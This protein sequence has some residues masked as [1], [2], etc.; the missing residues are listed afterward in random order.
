MT[1]LAT[2]SADPYWRQRK[3]ASAGEALSLL[4]G[5]AQRRQ[6][7]RR[8]RA[9][10]DIARFWKIGE[11]MPGVAAGAYGQSLVQ[12]YGKEFP[13]VR[14]LVETF[15]QRDKIGRTVDRAKTRYLDTLAEL[16]TDYQ[17]Q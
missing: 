17:T 12:K 8:Q 15:E 10:D 13:E 14:S 7:E 5:N 9:L 2:G 3:L 4:V 6:E 11:E 1:L 16:E